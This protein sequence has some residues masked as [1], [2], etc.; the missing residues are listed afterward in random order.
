[1]GS[2]VTII[3][4]SSQQNTA[5][6][7]YRNVGVNLSVTPTI[8]ENNIITL[9]I[10]TEISQTVGLPPDNTSANVN[11]ITTDLTTTTTRVH[12]PDGSFLV[13]SG[14]IN[15]T[16]SRSKEGF[17][18]LGSLPV[19]GAAFSRT[20]STKTKNNVMIFMRPKIVDDYEIYKQITERQEELASEEGTSDDVEA[21]FEL[22]KTPDD[23]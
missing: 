9:D 10:D 5:N 19:V 15:N 4:Q 2:T 21:A 1:T 6:L 7:E 18:C 17:P 12:V 16:T 8:G 3:G 11:G 23:E 22:I 14:Q 20:A 13:L